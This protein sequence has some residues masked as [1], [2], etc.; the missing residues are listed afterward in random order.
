MMQSS[1]LL[2][3]LALHTTDCFSNCFINGTGRVQRSCSPP[4]S[5]S[6]GGRWHYPQR[7][8]GRLRLQMKDSSVSAKTSCLQTLLEF[9]LIAETLG[10][11]S[12]ACF[13]S[14]Q[15]IS[16]LC[17]VSS[18][19]VYNLYL[20]TLQSHFHLQKM[21]HVRPDIRPLKN[22]PFVLHRRKKVWNN[23]RAS[24]CGENVRFGVKLQYVSC[25]FKAIFNAFLQI[26][27]WK[28]FFFIQ[29]LIITG[30]KLV[31][32]WESR[33]ITAL[34]RKPKWG[35]ETSAFE[36]WESRMESMRK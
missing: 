21:L 14:T 7:S 2:K 19:A 6:A 34:A 27:F 36:M 11:W 30:G 22:T 23:M 24:E 20:V 10:H 3:S 32:S 28:P 5:C 8:G 26:F 31:W 17:P 35:G 4:D 29:S 25:F 15:I 13:L 1:V 9:S 12:E 16:V 33:W 18:F